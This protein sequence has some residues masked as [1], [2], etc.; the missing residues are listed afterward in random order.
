MQKRQ[1]KG[2]CICRLVLNLSFLYQT[3]RLFGR[4]QSRTNQNQ[5]PP[6][7]TEHPG[8]LDSLFALTKIAELC[9]L[10]GIKLLVA[11]IS[12][13]G[14]SDFFT[15]LSNSGID[16]ISLGPAW[17]EIETSQHR[18]S[19]VDPHPSAPVHDRF[20]EHLVNELKARGWLGE[21]KPSAG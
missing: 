20:A 15:Q 11:R 14:D 21:I 3:T 13:S 16:A 18:V 1:L 12:G 6:D 17:E 8:W 5:R 4:M 7:I 9:K 10:N 2:A 19:R